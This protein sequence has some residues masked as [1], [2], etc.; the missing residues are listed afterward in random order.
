MVRQLLV[1]SSENTLPYKNQ[2]LEEYLLHNV[3]QGQ[4]ILYL[5]QNKHT[6]VIG[7][8]QNAWRDC[9]IEALE[10]DGG[11]LARRITGG[12]AV[13]HDLGN[14]NFT[15]LVKKEDYDVEKQTEVILKAVNMLGIQAEKT[16]RN[17]ITVDNR[18]FSGNAYCQT[19]DN[20]LHHGTI[21]VDANKIQMSE[22]LNVS[23][24]KLRSKG[25]TSVK[26]RVA[27]LS[28]F[29]PSLTIDE[30]KGALKK[31]FGLCYGLNPKG[32]EEAKIDWS[33]VAVREE[34]FCSWDWK[35]GRKIPFDYAV[36]ERF[37]WGEVQ[38]RIKVNE[39]RIAHMQ[40]F[41]DGLN[42][43]LP[44]ELRAVLEGSRYTADDLMAA[45]A[46]LKADSTLENQ[47]KQDMMQ[48]I[49]NTI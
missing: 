1:I 23:K 42:T 15:F 25:V 3:E 34:G 7:K 35:Y 5:W 43:E 13:F 12:G 40:I 41:T 18:K 39:G 21:M 11:F 24:E 8:N 49:C 38:L 20:C 6:V 4:C 30:V 9:R 48:L 45:A 22:Y 14:L 32:M 28:E 37:L 26:S 29:V 31:A 2:A 10:R 44:D 27:N 47:M 46:A 19:G 36:S 16:G 33:E 17:D